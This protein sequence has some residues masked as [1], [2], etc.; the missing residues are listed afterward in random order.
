[1][2]TSVIPAILNI[3]L[4]WLFVFPL[5]LGLMGAASAT[6][7]SEA[8]GAVMA[9]AYLVY[10]PKT[11]H[12]YR[13]KFTR[14]SVRLTVRNLGYMMKLGVPTFIAETAISGS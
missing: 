11:I 3:F 2:Y 5:N 7:I 4:D 13:P 12:L 6:S 1:M 8:V 14:T 9:V 10:F